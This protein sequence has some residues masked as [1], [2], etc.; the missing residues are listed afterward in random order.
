GNATADAKLFKSRCY[1]CHIVKDGGTKQVPNLHGIF[2][3]KTGQVSGYRYSEVNLQKGII[4]NEK[5][6]GIYLINPKKLIPGTKVI[7]AGYKK[8]DRAG[9][10][11]YLKH[12][13]NY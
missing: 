9:V 7:F 4:W 2:G 1:Q 10:I 5:F 6:L 8:K 12:L 11:A 13:K 3:R